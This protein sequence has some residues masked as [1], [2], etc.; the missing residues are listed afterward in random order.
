MSGLL[1]SWY[2]IIRDEKL[3]SGAVIILS[4]YSEIVATMWSWHRW[5]TVALPPPPPPLF[6]SPFPSVTISDMHRCSSNFHYCLS[7]SLS[8]TIIQL[9]F[10]TVFFFCN[11]SEIRKNSA[12][13]HNGTNFHFSSENTAIMLPGRK[14][15]LARNQFFNFHVCTR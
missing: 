3:I 11:T 15:P 1:L 10:I 9:I 14:A 2:L 7:F 5:C 6:S 4:R 13:W 8:P 12:M